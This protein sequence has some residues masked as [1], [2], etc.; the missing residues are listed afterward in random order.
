M[1]TRHIDE[2][3]L[4]FLPYLPQDEEWHDHFCHKEFY[5]VQTVDIFQ[6]NDE[7]NERWCRGFF[8]VDCRGNHSKVVLIQ[9]LVPG[10]LYHR[11]VERSL[12]SS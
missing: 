10:F 5:L 3:R 8:L 1:T 2:M 6:L 11:S 7:Q 9:K 12:D 4:R